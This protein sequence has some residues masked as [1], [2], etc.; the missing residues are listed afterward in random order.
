MNPTS[1]GSCQRAV[2]RATAHRNESSGYPSIAKILEAYRVHRQPNYMYRICIL[3]YYM[4]DYQYFI[5]YIKLL[6][7]DQ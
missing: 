7:D 1:D 4:V 5:A 3:R 6:S 2:E